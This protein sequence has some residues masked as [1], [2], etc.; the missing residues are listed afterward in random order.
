MYVDVVNIKSELF[1]GSHTYFQE[2]LKN[3]FETMTFF[4]YGWFTKY[5]IVCV[6]EF[7][8]VG[9]FG[10]VHKLRLQEVGTQ[11]MSTFIR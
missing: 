11:K 7:L 10:V 8:G 5:I 2:K 1:E 3:K 6:C 9:G 4:K